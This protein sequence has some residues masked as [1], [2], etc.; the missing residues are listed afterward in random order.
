[1]DKFQSFHF[2]VLFVMQNKVDA[3]NILCCQAGEHAHSGHTQSQWSSITLP[4]T[5]DAIIV[6]IHCN[7]ANTLP[8]TLY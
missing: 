3:S 8:I 6:K 5:C 7:L 2:P 4:Q 1:M